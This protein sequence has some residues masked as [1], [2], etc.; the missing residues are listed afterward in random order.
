MKI[1][2]DGNVYLE[3][4][5]QQF[6]LKEYTGKTYTNKKGEEVETYRNLGY[7]GTIQQAIKGIVRKKLLES[8]ATTLQEIK[9]DVNK[10]EK[11]IEQKINF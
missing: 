7:Y 10:L 6:L 9:S 5:D 8:D 2:L 1:K 11:Y 3:S 4:D